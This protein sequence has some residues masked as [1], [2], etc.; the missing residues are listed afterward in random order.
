MTFPTGK[1]RV[2]AIF[3]EQNIG[4]AIEALSE[5]TGRSA[6]A[7][8]VNGVEIQSCWTLR[9][10]LQCYALHASCLAREAAGRLRHL[11]CPRDRVFLTAFNKTMLKRCDRWWF[12]LGGLDASGE[13]FQ[14]DVDRLRRMVFR[15]E[16]VAC[17]AFDAGLTGRILEI[18]PREIE[19]DGNGFW[20][21]TSEAWIREY[22]LPSVL[23]PPIVP[24]DAR[25][26]KI[27]IGRVL[28][29]VM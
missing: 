5:T 25:L 24:R 9:A 23:L 29:P 7:V 27:W 20:I 16:S 21:K 14:L 10:R 17:P 19:L 26:Y 6:T 22:R 1:T 12:S 11:G 8:H 13:T 4:E 28:A 3:H 2:R 18:L 15:P